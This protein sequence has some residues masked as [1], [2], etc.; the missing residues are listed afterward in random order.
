MNILLELY[1]PLDDGSLYL[2][3][4][5]RFSSPIRNINALNKLTLCYRLVRTKEYHAFSNRIEYNEEENGP[6][7]S[8]AV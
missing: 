1:S 7:I 6:F 5:M 3:R 2:V 8:E 4:A